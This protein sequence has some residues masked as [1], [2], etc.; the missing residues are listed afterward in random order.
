MLIE[1][2]ASATAAATVVVS[3][4]GVVVVVVL[5]VVVVQV[6]WSTPNIRGVVVVVGFEGNAAQWDN[7]EG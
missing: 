6:G 2:H 7:E 4:E 1:H 3:R 5:V